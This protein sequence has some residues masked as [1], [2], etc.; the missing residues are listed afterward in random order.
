MVERAQETID[1]EEAERMAEKLQKA[2]FNLE[3]FLSHMRQVKKMGSFSSIASMLPGMG[4]MNIGDEEEQE[5]ARTEAIIL[6]MTP[7]ESQGE[8]VPLALNVRVI[9]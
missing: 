2:D 4:G 6:S 8:I 3:D 1:E 7:K 5:M 9:W